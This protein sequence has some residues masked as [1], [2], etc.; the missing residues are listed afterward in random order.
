MNYSEARK[1]IKDIQAR[2]GSDYSLQEVAEL[3]RR[4]GR[5][6]RDVPLVHI[7]GTN[8]KGSVGALLSHI[9]AAAGYTV[10]RFISPAVVSYREQIQ[11]ILPLDGMP[12][13]YISKENVAEICSRLREIADEMSAVGYTRPTAFEMETVMAFEMFRK[14]KVD[15]ALVECGMGGRLDATNII[16]KPVMCIFTSISRDHM[17]ILGDSL[18]QIA[19][20][21]YGI[22]KEGTSVVSLE[23][24]PCKDML[25][26]ICESRGASLYLA[27][28]P[29]PVSVSAFDGQVFCYNGMRYH[30]FQ[31]GFYQQENAALA[32]EAATRLAALG[33]GK[34]TPGAMEEGIYLSRWR[35]RFDVVSKDPFIL[36]DGAH[37]EDGAKKLCDSLKRAFP[38]ER[39]HLVVGVFKDKEYD[40]ILEIMLPLAE[41]VFTVTAPGERGLPAKCL[42]EAAQKLCAVPV[43]DC[44][45]VEQAIGL[46]TKGQTKTVCFGSLSILRNCLK[47]TCPS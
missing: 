43:A 6:D 42:K 19:A 31:G 21:K 1:Y 36:V 41:R 15:V 29:E 39:F 14:W 3:A 16:E 26:S 40:K 37:N 28:R 2:L 20:E 38:E 18:Q 22:I 44:E 27:H 46:S 33:F 10:G 32:L 23:G 45:T 12:V 25:Y 13:E 47:I 17:A 34:I 24:Q 8:G 35:G 9:L 30:M 5:P 7:A 4:M 11:R